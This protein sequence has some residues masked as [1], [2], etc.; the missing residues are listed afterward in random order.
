RVQLGWTLTL[1]PPEARSNDSILFVG[2]NPGS[3]V[4]VQGLKAAG[5]KVTTVQD[6][7]EPDQVK[8][9]DG[10]TYDVSTKDGALAFAGTL[11]MDPEVAERVGIAIFNGWTDAHDEIAGI[12]AVW[13]GAERGETI[14]SRLV[15]SGHSV[16][17]G[18]WGEENG[19]LTLD[20]VADLAAAMP[21]AARSI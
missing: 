16:G 11:G 21:K 18:V 17:Q 10:Q 15:L 3:T 12:A 9:P 14:P 20:S 1:P 6:S 8:G 7:A 4:E 19:T 13:A 2:M 5:A